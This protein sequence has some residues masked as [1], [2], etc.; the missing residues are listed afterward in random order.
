MKGDLCLK[1]ISI[2]IY[3]FGQLTDVKI[4]NLSDFHVFYGENEA[5][6]STVMAFIHGILFGFPTKQQAELRYEPKHHNSYGGKLKIFTEE[7]GVA[8]IERVKGKAAA[9]DVSVITDNGLSGGEDLLKKL[10]ANVD[11]G[12]FQAIFSFNLH[13][14]QNIH[15]MKGEDIGK[16]IFSAG[17]LGT[18]RLV[19]AD[20]ELQKELEHRFKPGGKKPYLNEKLLEVNQLHREL[21]AAAAKNQEYEALVLQKDA[22]QN[23]MEEIII[24]LEKLQEQNDKMNEWKK[25]A[26]LVKEEKWLKQELN[27]LGELSFPPR[28]IERFENL[29]PLI[30]AL[31]AQMLSLKERI[32]RLSKEIETLEPNHSFLEKEAEILTALEKYPLYSQWQLQ[33]EQME[34]KLHQF[35]DKLA[36]IKEKLHL[37]LTEEEIAAVNTNIYMRD[38]AV[39]LSRRGQALEDLKYQLEKRFNEEKNA[40]EAVEEEV[41]FIEAG[42]MTEEDRKILETQIN[43]EMDRNHLEMKLQAVRDKIDIYKRAKLQELKAAERFK[44][45][46]QLQ[47]SLFAVL[48]LGLVFYGFYSGQTVLVLLGAVGF[49]LVL[50]LLF[51]NRRQPNPFKENDSLRELLQE[52]QQLL[53][54]LQSHDARKTAELQERLS[55]DNRRREK[56]KVLGIKLVE[57]QNQYEKVIKR[58]EEWELEAAEHKEDVNKMTRQLKI[59][60]SMGNS[61]LMEAF[62]LIEQ[63]KAAA[64]EKQQLKENL[65]ILKD[66]QRELQDELKGFAVRFLNREDIGFQDAAYLLRSKLKEEQEKNI[67]WKEK[68]M[69]LAELTADLSQ[70]EEENAH[71]TAELNKLLQTADVKTEKEFYELG[72]KDEKKCKLV[73]RI[74]DLAKQLHY[75]FLDESEWDV[76]LQIHD[77]EEI[78]SRHKQEAAA[79]QSR[80]KKLQEQLASI[81]YEIQ[82]LEEGGL[83]SEL[84]HQFKEKKYE[85]EEDAKEWAAYSLAQTILAQTVEK[86]KNLH[87]PKLLIKAEEFLVYLTDGNYQKILLH[88]SG[89]GFLIVRTDQTVFEA[90]ELSQATAEQVYVSIRLALAVTIYEKYRFPIIIDDSFVNFDSKRTKKVIGLLKQLPQNQILFFTC[91]E[92]LLKYFEKGNIL[93]LNKGAIQLT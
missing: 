17:T 75:S 23:E 60:E 52:E 73:E 91:H 21:K 87:L 88:Q 4:A 81:K 56:L 43:K 1:I 47:Y 77:S 76:L 92:H 27:L 63:Y 9:G 29:Q 64:R 51:I 15:Q 83:Y 45:Q 7:M 89:P 5:G 78:I 58:F 54:Y 3:G 50:S 86:Y 18:D 44:K 48:L 6:K 55:L 30:S 69:K 22:L 66:N 26:P 34:V 19:Y 93:Y 53:Q 39:K 49:V 42:V 74:E 62:V 11:R 8:V 61:F 31:D 16:F 12:L 20:N 46:K 13:G 68:Q 79:L 84:L 2:T 82:M 65:K 28:G 85:L 37:T 35:A 33:E 24:Q 38:L 80:L 71:L 32:G 40:L 57:Q 36:E 72:A 10:L 41:H 90:N 25:I 70:L 59:P 67:Q 14:L